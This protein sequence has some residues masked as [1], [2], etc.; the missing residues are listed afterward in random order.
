VAGS[1][2][3]VAAAS[4]RFFTAGPRDAT[5]YSAPLIQLLPTWAQSRSRLTGLAC[6]WTRFEYRKHQEALSPSP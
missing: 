4:D 5:W 1:V 6:L 2:A 3:S